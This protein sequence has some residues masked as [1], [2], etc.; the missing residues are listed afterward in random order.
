MRRFFVLVLLLVGVLLPAG[1]AQANTWSSL[2]SPTREGYTRLTDH[3]FSQWFDCKRVVSGEWDCYDRNGFRMRLW[4]HQE[5]YEDFDDSNNNYTINHCTALVVHTPAG[6]NN[7]SAAAAEELAVN[8]FRQ[9]G[10]ITY[11]PGWGQY[12]TVP[13]GDGEG[14]PGYVC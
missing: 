9:F 12:Q 2:P 5:I 8:E 6:H 13:N 1:V 7:A 3:T 10:G 4:C 11:L 14:G